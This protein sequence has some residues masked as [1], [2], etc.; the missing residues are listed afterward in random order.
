MASLSAVPHEVVPRAISPK[1]TIISRV[2]LVLIIAISILCLLLRVASLYIIDAKKG[3]IV[4]S[5]AKKFCFYCHKIAG[6]TF[7]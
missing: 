3:Q 4:A 1:A 5:R 6:Y 7:F 2:F